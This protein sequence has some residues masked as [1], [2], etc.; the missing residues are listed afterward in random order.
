MALL[1]CGVVS[2][3]SEDEQISP[4]STP[5]INTRNLEGVWMLTQI[6]GIELGEDQ[7]LYIELVHADLTFDMY[8][9]FDSAYSHQSVGTFGVDTDDD[10]RK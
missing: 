10:G 3:Q 2:C 4:D 1:L 6:E 7:Y 9:N 8:D 5:V